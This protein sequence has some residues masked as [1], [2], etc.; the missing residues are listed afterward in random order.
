[1]AL[2]PLG[3]TAVAQNVSGFMR[4][5]DQMSGG[6]QGVGRRSNELVNQMSNLGTKVVKFGLAAGA[7]A[8]TGIAALGAGL[9]KLAIDAAPLEGIQKGFEGLT[10]SIEGG[11]T[12]MLAALKESSAGMVTNIDL[13]KSFNLAAQLISTDFAEQLPNAMQYLS[14]VAAATGQDMSYMMDSLVRG[15]GRLSP[16]ILDN[17][18]VQVD[19]TTAY[20]KWAEENGVAVESMT[21]TE[22]QMAVMN[23]VMVQLAKNTADMPDV[24]GTAAQQWSAFK[25][26]L[27]DTRNEIGLSLLPIMS[28]LLS[29]IS[30]LIQ[31]ALPAL[32]ELFKEKIIPAIDSVVGYFVNLIEILADAGIRSGEFREALTAMFP[33]DVQQRIFRAIETLERWVDLIR[34]FVTEHKDK[35]IAAI[36]GIAVALAA[37]KIIT[38][39]Q[40]IARII[41]LL[42]SSVLPIL[43]IAA[44]LGVAWSENWLGIRDI[45]TNVWENTLKP[46]VEQVV[47][48]FKI[49]IPEAITAVRTFFENALPVAGAVAEGVFG[50]ILEFVE[51]I[52]VWFME[53][54]PVIKAVFLTAWEVIKA[55][56]LS[57]IEVIRPHIERLIESFQ[58][59]FTPER[60]EIFKNVI[61]GVATA[62][63]AIL[64][65]L[66][67]LVVGIIGGVADA[68]SVIIQVFMKVV[69]SVS[70]IIDGFKKILEGDLLGGIIQIFK[71]IAEGVAN[72]IVGLIAALVRLGTTLVETVINFFVDL[73]NR[74]VGHSLVGDIV[75]GI[76]KSFKELPGRLLKIG[77]EIISGLWNGLISAWD[78]VKEW[79]DSTIGGLVSDIKDFLGLGS[80]S[81]LF[82]GFGIDLMKGL[83]KGIQIGATLP[84]AATQMAVQQMAAPVV[85]R[86]T[87]N[88]FN[89]N[90]TTMAPRESLIADYQMLAAMSERS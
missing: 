61:S 41:G 72:I 10:E 26:T 80:P 51:K 89:L 90:V 64:Q 37:A 83:A 81:K 59:L 7:A 62:V 39:I 71:S 45:V 50:R 70:G 38:T 65:G 9:A 17:L 63:G 32:V 75:E 69:E 29:R 74:L 44:L 40:N 60:I 48:W 16:M 42:G 24:V 31:Q 49:K 84:A 54:W 14:K 47:E 85:S 22:Q 87:T 82:A 12:A 15:V 2:Q 20:E 35:I 68:I 78:N 67:G 27:Q 52:R 6:I 77:K 33:D 8:A 28:H 21:K 88:N 79:F 46:I 18:A 57:A 55:N 56:V 58:S 5:M 11:S 4:S 13:M 3:I 25:V 30:P 73:Y 43:A 66:F 86:Q 76:I 23:E 1:M 34:T 36:E 19:L 53:N